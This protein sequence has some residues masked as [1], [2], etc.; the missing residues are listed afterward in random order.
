MRCEKENEGMVTWLVLTYFCGCDKCNFRQ[1]GINKIQYLGIQTVFF[2]FIPPAFLHGTMSSS[3][4][5]NTIF[6]LFHFTNWKIVNIYMNNTLLIKS[7]RLYL[8]CQET[9]YV[10]VL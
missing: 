10:I 8:L 2:V 5:K 9:F 1:S 6:L 3:K 7:H 4:Y